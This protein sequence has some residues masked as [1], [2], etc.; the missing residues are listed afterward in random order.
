MVSSPSLRSH[1]EAARILRIT[2]YSDESIREILRE[3]PDPF[4]LERYR[5]I[6]A[7]YGVSAELLMD[8]MG[9]SP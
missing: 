8:R 2:G 4:D 1:E 5:E 9:G 3:L 7:R 6:L